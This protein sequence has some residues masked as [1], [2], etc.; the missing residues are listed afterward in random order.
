[1]YFVL[2]FPRLPNLSVKDL[3][4]EADAQSSL[5]SP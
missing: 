2:G 3:K 1:M 4:H 5:S